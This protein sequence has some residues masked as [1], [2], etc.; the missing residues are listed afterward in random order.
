M[1]CDVLILYLIIAAIYVQSGNLYYVPG[2]FCVTKSNFFVGHS[3]KCYGCTTI[4]INNKNNDCIKGTISAM[5]PLDCPFLT[6]CVK[7][8]YTLDGKRKLIKFFKKFLQSLFT[9]CRFQIFQT[10]LW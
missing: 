1:K 8:E 6:T 9:I 5:V 4:V 10:G 2:N 7:Y 3:I